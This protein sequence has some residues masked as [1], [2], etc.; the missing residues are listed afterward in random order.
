M[1]HHM[2]YTWYISS[3][4][5]NLSWKLTP[6]AWPSEMEWL[7]E[8]LNS[9]RWTTIK[10][11]V[12]KLRF[13]AFWSQ[14]TPRCCFITLMNDEFENPKYLKFSTNCDLKQPGLANIDEKI[15]SC[16]NLQNVFKQNWFGKIAVN[17]V[18]ICFDLSF[19]GFS[20]S[21]RVSSQPSHLGISD[22][23]I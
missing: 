2:G 1:Y 9:S 12:L 4:G 16:W 10:I 8:I 21:R 13:K 22:F 18:F 23:E 3:Y 15:F 19:K 17:N 14:L 6:R 7:S 11:E 5:R 20:S